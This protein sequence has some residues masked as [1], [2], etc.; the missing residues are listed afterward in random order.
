MLPPSNDDHDPSAE[1]TSEGSKYTETCKAFK[2]TP[3]WEAGVHYIA[4]DGP[5]RILL[6]QTL[7]PSA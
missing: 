3:R 5:D 4:L 7:L 2:E 6:P 1:W